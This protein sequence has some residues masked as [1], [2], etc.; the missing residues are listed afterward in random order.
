MN[1]EISSFRVRVYIDGVSLTGKHALVTV[2]PG[3]EVSVQIGTQHLCWPYTDFLG[4]LFHQ[5][6]VTF[7][8]L[9]PT[10]MQ[11]LSWDLFTGLKT[12]GIIGFR[13]RDPC[14]LAS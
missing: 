10:E 11:V 5:S 13:R 1:P 3:V 2:V 8:K 9:W 4:R 14:Q 6:H 12:S 7:F